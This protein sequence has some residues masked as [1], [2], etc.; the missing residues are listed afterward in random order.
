MRIP[1]DTHEEHWQ[2]SAGDLSYALFGVYIQ[3][4]VFHKN[5]QRI[6]GQQTDT[7]WW[8]KRNDY[9]RHGFVNSNDTRLTVID[10]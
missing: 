7:A 8:G 9:V 6:E 1:H 4:L 3:I 5:E 10:T 2:I